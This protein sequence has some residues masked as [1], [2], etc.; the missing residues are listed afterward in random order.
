MARM[1]IPLI[2][3]VRSRRL[4]VYSITLAQRRESG[5]FDLSFLQ[6]S[7]DVAQERAPYLDVKFMF[8]A[9]PQDDVRLAERGASAHADRERCGVQIQRTPGVEQRR[10]VFP[11][12]EERA[13]AVAD[14]HE[15][16]RL[17]ADGR[18][19]PLEPLTGLI[20]GLIQQ[21][22]FIGSEP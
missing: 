2:L 21:Q 20:G 16:M 22:E 14:I 17:I 19:E 13:L 5:K 6:A 1:K 15:R 9:S 4:N 11:M 18:F 10:G 3:V 12:D 8:A 7:A